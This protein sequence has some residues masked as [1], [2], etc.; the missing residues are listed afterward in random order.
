MDSSSLFGFMA[1]KSDFFA[2]DDA[3]APRGKPSVRSD[4][5][6]PSHPVEPGFRMGHHWCLEI[7]LWLISKP[8]PF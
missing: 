5:E 4:G 6:P 7:P 3:V 2:G 8:I 1:S